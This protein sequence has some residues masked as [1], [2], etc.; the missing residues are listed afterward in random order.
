MGKN[1]VGNDAH[2]VP[3]VQ[4]W[5]DRQ[6]SQ[7]GEHLRYR[8]I[9]DEALVLLVDYSLH[10]RESLSVVLM[11]GYRSGDEHAGI[12]EDVNHNFRMS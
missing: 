4:P 1:S 9:A 2:H 11:C 3:W 7:N 12:K 6:S 8:V 5:N 10:N